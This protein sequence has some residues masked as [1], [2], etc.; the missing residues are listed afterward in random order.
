[1]RAHAHSSDHLTGR[2]QPAAVQ[3]RE[4]FSIQIQMNSSDHLTGRRQ[5]AAV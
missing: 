5:P 4:N 3:P 2:R 1:M